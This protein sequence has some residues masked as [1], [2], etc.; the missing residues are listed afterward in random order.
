MSKLDNIKNNLAGRAL[1]IAV[2]KTRKIEQIMA[3]YEQGQRDFGENRV[4]ELAMKAEQLPQI[5]WHFIGHLQTNKVRDV[6]RYAHLIHSLDRMNL[7]EALQK[8]AAKQEKT[9]DVLIQVNL[10]Q[11]ETKGGFAK[12][13]VIPF[14]QTMDRYPSLC[15]RGIMCM[16][17]HVED[18]DQIQQVFREAKNLFLAC[19]EIKHV[20]VCMDYLSMGMSD[21]YLIALAEGSNMVRIGSLL[22]A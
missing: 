2:S 10:A 9:I 13:E 21:D 14:L 17:P 22:F 18:Q 8:E 20:Q 19:K 1:L 16:G 6:V 15:I 3:L 5:Q 7:A 4:Q 11:E 12:E